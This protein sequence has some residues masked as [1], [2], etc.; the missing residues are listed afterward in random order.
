[1]FSKHKKYWLSDF[2]C[3]HAPAF[4]ICKLVFFLSFSS[5]SS[6]LFTHHTWL[7]VPVKVYSDNGSTCSNQ[8]LELLCLEL[9]QETKLLRHSYLSTIGE[10]CK[11]AKVSSGLVSVSDFPRIC[12]FAISAQFLSR[13][14]PCSN[15]NGVI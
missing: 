10:I 12:T 1:M 7:N 2:F 6:V 15:E 13:L 14:I 9:L 3:F 8:L 11:T 4:L 5:L